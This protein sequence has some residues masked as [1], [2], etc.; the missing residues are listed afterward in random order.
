MDQLNYQLKPNTDVNRYTNYYCE[1]LAVKNLLDS[2]RYQ[3]IDRTSKKDP[4]PI[5]CCEFGAQNVLKVKFMDSKS[6][7]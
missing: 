6:E 4:K 5:K 7:E 2:L 1:N 3:K